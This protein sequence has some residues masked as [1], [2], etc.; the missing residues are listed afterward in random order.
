MAQTIKI[1]RSSSATNPSGLEA[2]EIAYIHSN[3][4]EG[5][6]YIGRPGG[7]ATPDIDVIGGKLF[8]DKLDGIDAGAEVNPAQVSEAERTAGTEAGERSFSPA[9]VKSM[10]DTHSDDNPSQVSEAERTAGTETAT[11]I[12][13]PADIK[14]MIDTHSDNNHAGATVV[15]LQNGTETA[16][17]SFS[18]AEIKS[19]IDQHSDDNYAQ[20]ASGDLT[21]S[22]PTTDLKSFSPSDVKAMIDNH[23]DDNPA[24]V[25]E[26]ERTAGTVTATRLYSPAD[27][28]S[29]IETHALTGA[30]DIDFTG[31]LTLKGDFTNKAYPNLS[32]IYNTDRTIAE[33]ADL[34]YLMTAEPT[35]Y[36]YSEIES[37]YA[38]ALDY[39]QD[40]R[41]ASSDGYAINQ[42]VYNN[43]SSDDHTAFNSAVSG[44]TSFS[45]TFV[46]DVLDGDYDLKVLV[47]DE[48]NRRVGVNTDTPTEALDVSG[49]I[50]ASGTIT[51]D[52]DVVV[53]GNLTVSGTTTTVNTETIELADNQILLNSNLADDATTGLEDGGISINRGAYVNAE[54]L[55]DESTQEWKTPY[56][57]NATSLGYL[58]YA[59]LLT[60]ENASSKNYDIDG[61]T[62]S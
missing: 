33:L 6:L 45:T 2:G 52:G 39:N 59:T 1:K 60:T 8:I 28:K 5:K 42:F 12:Y 50:K 14:S 10:I 61:G 18:P 17:R 53:G 46:D 20:V 38:Q 35:G 55:W 4:T 62:F 36:G 49:N 7:G 30:T 21:T 15:E 25:S 40:G 19:M 11:R 58:G 44:K 27:V 26:A 24:Q 13:S 56:W 54:L 31:D 43:Y 51:S 47:T 16:E 3:D 32:D 34:S 23:S 22:N 48:N 41:F 57:A 37:G 29:M 9:D